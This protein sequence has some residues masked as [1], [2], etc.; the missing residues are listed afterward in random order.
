MPHTSQLGGDEPVREIHRVGVGAGDK[1]E[2]FAEQGGVC[3]DRRDQK[4]G[5][6]LAAG[7]VAVVPR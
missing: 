4:T 5:G 3:E 7:R 1:A 6:G 2:E